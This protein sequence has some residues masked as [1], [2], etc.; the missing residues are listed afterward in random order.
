MAGNQAPGNAELSFAASRQNAL[1]GKT[2]RLQN[3]TLR[4]LGIIKT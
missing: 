3:Y 2:S 1:Y 4:L